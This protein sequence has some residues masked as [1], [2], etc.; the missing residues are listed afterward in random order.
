MCNI[1]G[2]TV[3]SADLMCIDKISPCENVSWRIQQRYLRCNGLKMRMGNI[4]ANKPMKTIFLHYLVKMRLYWTLRTI[5]SPP[6][7]Q[8]QRPGCQLTL[9]ISSYSEKMTD[10]KDHYM[11]FLE[12]MFK[13]DM[14]RLPPLLKTTRNVGIF[15]V[16]AFITN[17]KQGRSGQCL[18][19]VTN[20]TSP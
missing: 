5:N 12:T 1:V 15:Q 13:K 10:M 17:K 20:T 2:P 11:E 4:S 14:L 3:L 7:A 6:F 16:L 19:Q 9:I 18:I 8:Q